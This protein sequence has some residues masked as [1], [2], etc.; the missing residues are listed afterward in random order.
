VGSLRR[1]F[2]V[3][4]RVERATAFLLAFERYGRVAALDGAFTQLRKLVETAPD[5]P[6]HNRHLSDLCGTLIRKYESAGKLSDLEEAIR[7]GQAAVDATPEGDPN[8]CLYLSNLSAGWQLRFSHTGR[9]ED[10]ER[11]VRLGEDAVAAT[12]DDHHSRGMFL[13]N[14]GVAL[15]RLFERVGRPADLEKAV[16]VGQD[17]VAA[18]PTT[19]R[20]YALH[21]LNLGLAWL[22]R[23]ERMGRPE[24]LEEAV[25]RTR[26]ATVAIRDNHAD[27]GRYWSNLGRALLLR[28]ELSDHLPDLEEAVQASQRAVDAIRVGHPNRGI[29]LLNL[30]SALWQ[31]FERTG[32]PVDLQAA[33]RAFTEAARDTSGAIDVRVDAA[34]GAADTHLAAEDVDSALDMAELGVG[35]L[36]L[37]APRRL[38]RSDRQHRVTSVHGLAATAATAA[39]A[40]GRGDRAV[41]LL[42]QTRGLLIADTLDTRG[43][44]FTLQD[45]APDLA[46][47]FAALREELDDLDHSGTTSLAS[48]DAEATHQHDATRR[49]DLVA[50]WT[51]L[52][53]RIR[54]VPGLSGFLEPPPIETLRRAAEDGP[55]V[56]VV[57]HP[58]AGHSIVLRDRSTEP[59]TVVPLPDLTVESATARG[60]TLRSATQGR[61]VSA[62]LTAQEDLHGVLEWMWDTITG[63]TLEAL[64]HTTT[65]DETWPRVWW[66]PVG[67]ATRLP[68]HAA[69]HHRTPSHAHTVM[70]RVISSYTPT[71]RALLHSR[72]PTRNTERPVSTLVITVPDA[73]DFPL[74]PGA[75]KETA[76]LAELISTA[77]VLPADG[78]VV[79]RDEVLAAL[80]D[81]EVVHFACHGL[82]DWA[83]PSNSTLVLHDHGTSPLTVA[84]ITRQR[85]TRARL[86]YLS[87]CS[88]TDTNLQ[89][90]DEATHLTATFQLAGYRSVIGTLWPVDDDAATTISRTV[91]TYLTKRGTTP[92][93]PG[94]AAHALHKAI[95]HHRDDRL[96]RPTE[97][98]AHVHTGH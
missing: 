44:L 52:L 42:E 92:P 32:K 7:Y 69:G 78:G 62:L 65:P 9:L 94:N 36:G 26:E 27:R 30:G 25:R 22:R 48:D 73:P 16:R 82:A 51:E 76:Q 54:E 40:A 59:T 38:R 95:R 70:D 18:T 67:I 34:R 15:Q 14:Y 58:Y 47:E 12:P 84:E 75:T 61:T 5:H 72:V 53:R 96:D 80:P 50:R 23:F 39:L 8:R 56:Y 17:A 4:Y 33:R 2:A 87:A 98:S 6:Q 85:L 79:T 11:A 60:E 55:V 66:C 1:E 13:S 90:A 3:R 86:A 29:Y 49:E 37:L 74:L 77:A 41:E 64:D 68:L 45:T 24:D 46:V 19:H 88:T 83:D 63:P 91:Y 93:D 31:R 71:V 81:H 20:Y 35:L 28:F 97:W 57:I 43:E 89:H 21:R 10:L